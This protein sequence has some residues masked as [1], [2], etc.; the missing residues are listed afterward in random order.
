MAAVIQSVR[1]DILLLNE[2]DYQA[3]SQVVNAFAK[4]YLAVAQHDLTPIEYPYVYSAPSNTG[5]D[6]SLDLNQNGKLHEPDDSW[7]YGSYPGQYAFAILSRYPIEST[8]TR[9]FQ[10][11][12]WSQLPG[13]IKPIHPETKQPYFNDELWKQLRLSSKNH[14]DV[15]IDIHG[16][17]LHVLA[18]HPTPL[19]S[20]GLKIAMVVV[21]MM[22]SHSGNTT[23]KTTRP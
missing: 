11:F 12:R 19:C 14:V 16:H 6:S 9:T 5:I 4:Q 8:S 7:G 10:N 1:P 21:T 15:S 2:I 20:M 3:D 13:A 23:S 18:S 22:R 17:T